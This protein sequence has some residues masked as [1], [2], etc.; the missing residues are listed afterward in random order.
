MRALCM[1]GKVFFGQILTG[2]ETVNN[3]NVSHF[4]RKS[5]SFKGFSNIDARS[6]FLVR[7]RCVVYNWH[8]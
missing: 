1:S 7:L 8:K 2:I 6:W 5:H 4:S 3:G